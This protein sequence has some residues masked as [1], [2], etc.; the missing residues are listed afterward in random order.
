LSFGCV[1]CACIPFKQNRSNTA[2][3]AVKQNFF[4]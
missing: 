3:A 2:I 4:I 1:V